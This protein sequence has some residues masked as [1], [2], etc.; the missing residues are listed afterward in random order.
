MR[1]AIFL[2]V[3]RRV[4]IGKESGGKW[5]G[6]RE[7]TGREQGDSRVDGDDVAAVAVGL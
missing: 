1:L 3:S 4:V 2:A 6:N 5:E 7:R